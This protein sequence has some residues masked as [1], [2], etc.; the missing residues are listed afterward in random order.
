MKYLL[1]S[2]NITKTNKK[3]CTIKHF[4]VDPDVFRRKKVKALPSAAA[5]LYYCITH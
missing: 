3:L 4:N 2:M 1:I 5:I